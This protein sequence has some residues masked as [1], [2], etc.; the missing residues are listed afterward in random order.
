MKP[1][2]ALGTVAT[3]FAALVFAALFTLLGI[4]FGWWWWA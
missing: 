1:D 2:D 4:G 3:I